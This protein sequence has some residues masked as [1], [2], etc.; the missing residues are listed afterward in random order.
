MVDHFFD[1]DAYRQRAMDFHA[2]DFGDLA[3]FGQ[4]PEF[5]ENLIELFFVGHGEDFLSCDLAVVQFDAAVSQAGDDGVVRHHDDGASLL[6]EFAQQAQDDLFV[7]GVEVARG[8]VGKNDLGIVDQGA[9]DADAL[10]LATGK[11]RRERGGRA[12]SIP[13]AP[14]LRALLARPSCCGS[15]APA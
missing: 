1:G 13:R 14:G 15:I 11:L 4:R 8:L 5:F 3:M 2:A 12:P 6:M 7:N 10:L 9:R